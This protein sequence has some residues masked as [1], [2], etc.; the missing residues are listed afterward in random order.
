MLSGSIFWYLLADSS[1][2]MTET[3]LKSRP[4]AID[5]KLCGADNCWFPEQYNCYLSSQM[6]F[7]AHLY[8]L[9][10]LLCNIDFPLYF[11]I[12]QLGPVKKKITWIADPFSYF[13]SLFTINTVEAS[14]F[15]IKY[16]SIKKI[17]NF[18]FSFTDAI[19]FSTTFTWKI[20]RIWSW[21]ITNHKIVVVL[22]IH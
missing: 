2:T 19:S 14:C 17:T 12:L 8:F 3:N 4:F 10:S 5:F 9:M 11:S 21:D 7:F 18:N 20:S 1:R 13:N 22:T 6:I 16:F 15:S